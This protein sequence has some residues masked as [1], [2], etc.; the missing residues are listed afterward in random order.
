MALDQYLAE[1]NS[2]RDKILEF[3]SFLLR[4]H[5]DIDHSDFTED[6]AVAK[7]MRRYDDFKAWNELEELAI[8]QDKFEEILQR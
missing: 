7:K 3:F 2:I 1:T 4:Y 6:P 5:R 8:Q